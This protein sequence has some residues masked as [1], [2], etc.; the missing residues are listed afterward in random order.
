[1]IKARMTHSC[2]CNTVSA[3]AA[4]SPVSMR[5]QLL[6]SLSAEKLHTL[7]SYVQA[8]LCPQ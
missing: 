3:A 5:K 7:H 1:M 4:V 2:H 8:R 6:L